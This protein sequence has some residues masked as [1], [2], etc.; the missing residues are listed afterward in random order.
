LFQLAESVPA[1]SGNGPIVTQPTVPME[2]I[3]CEPHPADVLVAQGVGMLTLR[4]EQQHITDVVGF[5]LRGK[6]QEATSFAQA[7]RTRLP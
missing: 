3:E 1:Q 6:P 2:H 7:T 5:A 4:P